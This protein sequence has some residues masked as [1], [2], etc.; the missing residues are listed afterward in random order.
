MAIT[1]LLDTNIISYALRDPM[2]R[3]ARQIA[4]VPR[5]QVAM[6]II[7][8]MELRFGLSKTP[9]VRNKAVVE[10]VL[11]TVPVANLPDGIAPI[12]GALRADLERRG[13]PIGPLDTIIAA[14]ALALG[15]VLVTSN[16]KE[17]RR[18]AK[19]QCEDWAAVR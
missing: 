9:S 13:T 1:Y 15:C 5:E 6:S 18:V 16:M 17:F 7:T 14:H 4:A 12:Y 11:A 10:A 8:A 2:K 3:V 19:L